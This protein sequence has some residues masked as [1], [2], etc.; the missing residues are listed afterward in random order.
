MKRKKRNYTG[1]YKSYYGQRLG[2]LPKKTIY[3][4]NI[5]AEHPETGNLVQLSRVQ[6]SDKKLFL[7]QNSAINYLKKIMKKD[8]Y[9]SHTL[10]DVGVVK[11]MSPNYERGSSIVFVTKKKGKYAKTL[12]RKRS[13]W[14]NRF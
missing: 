10:T 1:E 12:K 13:S 8:C 4:V 2:A 14:L 5:H 7:S 11:K 3:T 6:P 9:R